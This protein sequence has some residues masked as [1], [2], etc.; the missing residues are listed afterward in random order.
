MRL[1][2]RRW[3]E[4]LRCCRLWM[5]GLVCWLVVSGVL[6]FDVLGFDFLRRSNTYIHVG[7]TTSYGV[8]A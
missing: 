8:I 7:V 2:W 6:R 5:L 3:G 4:S 1:M